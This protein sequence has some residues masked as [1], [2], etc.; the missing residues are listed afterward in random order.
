MPLDEIKKSLYKDNHARSMG[1][2]E[3][4][5]F[6]PLHAESDSNP[7]VS[8]HEWQSQADAIKRK[9][10]LIWKIVGG[11]FIFVIVLGGSW[12]GYGVW[13]KNSFLEDRVIVSIDGP[14]E[15]DSN[16]IVQYDV[17]FTNNNRAALHDAEIYLEY[18]ENF[19]PVDNVNLKYISKGSS[20]LYIGDIKPRSSETFQIKG[21][22]YAPKDFQ[23]YLRASLKYKVL[24]RESAY[25]SKSQLGVNI[26]TAPVV[27]DVVLP[28]ESVDGDSV[29]CVIDYKNLD[30]R[31]ISEGQVKIEYPQGFQFTS[32]TPSPSKGGNVWYIGTLEQN[33]GGKIRLQ[34]KISGNPDQIR[35]FKIMIGRESEGGDFVVYNQRSLQ[36]KMIAAAFSISQEME[37]G[38]KN[39]IVLPGEELAYLVKFKNTSSIG[40]RNAIVTVELSGRVLDFSK[41][42][43]EKGSFDESKGLITWKASDVSQL[44]ILEPGAE[45]QVRFKIPVKEMIPVEKDTDK[46]Y[47]VRSVAKIDSADI[48]S[49]NESNKIIGSDILELKLG[50][51]VLFETLGFYNDKNIQ[52]SGPMPLQIGKETTYVMHWNITSVS[53]DIIDS[54]VSAT[55]PSGV[56]W[57][58]KVYPENEKIS[59]D[60]RSNSIVWKIGTVEA[61]AGIIKPKREVS[62]QI[63]ITPQSNQ[64]NRTL[65]LLNKSSFSGNDS[66]TSQSLILENNEKDTQLREDS[67]I[68]SSGYKVSG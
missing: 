29:E 2:H 5:N 53:N 68:D 50:S 12:Y 36:M 26:A 32:A 63:G 40:M 3:S 54:K 4:D 57:T 34:G 25:E 24:N 52:N 41:L 10:K 27:L 38:A 43:A 11:I 51:K 17:T 58:G 6:D 56:R 33:Q 7:F 9:R 18:A 48:P 45:G 28:R 35:T 22:F 60:S 67:K 15:A 47:V 66:F 59:Y 19:Q 39:G 49:S 64:L 14:Q 8:Q 16:E 13:K 21:T 62:F 23:V 1:S 42:N 37:M 20:K 30:V 44:A 31:S 61:G 55:L 65:I 46:N